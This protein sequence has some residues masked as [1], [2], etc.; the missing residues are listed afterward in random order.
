MIRVAIASVAGAVGGLVGGV[1]SLKTRPKGLKALFALTT[2][3]A[4]AFMVV[5]ALMPR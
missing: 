5:I 3:G 4:A 2:R 1:L